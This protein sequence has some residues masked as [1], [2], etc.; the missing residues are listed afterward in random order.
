VD[1]S[2]RLSQNVGV[3]LRERLHQAIDRAQETFEVE[4]E[5]EG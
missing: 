2:V 3:T 5:L 1:S 4:Q